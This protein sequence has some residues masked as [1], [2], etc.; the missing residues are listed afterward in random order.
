MTKVRVH[1]LA[2]E[3]GMENKELVDLLQKKNVDV[4]NHMSKL[5]EDVA[6]QIRKE[7]AGQAEK[8][9]ESRKERMLLREL[10]RQTS[11]EEEKSGLCNPASEFQKQQ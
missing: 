2:Q 6:S 1:E 8:K 9:E 5:E 10:I 4:K 7:R 11:S 3:L